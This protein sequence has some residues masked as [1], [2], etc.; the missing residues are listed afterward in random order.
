MEAFRQYNDIISS[1]LR[2]S[3]SDP[4]LK[5]GHVEATVTELGDHT[6]I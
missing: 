4:E 1:R 3:L 5:E 2:W 6:Y